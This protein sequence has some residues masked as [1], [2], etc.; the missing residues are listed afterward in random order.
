MGLPL[1]RHKHGTRH[2]ERKRSYIYMCAVKPFAGVK[3]VLVKAVKYVTGYPICNPV[4]GDV[5]CDLTRIELV[6]CKRIP[7]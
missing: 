7:T 6:Q 2:R 4:A 3:S 5:F 1:P